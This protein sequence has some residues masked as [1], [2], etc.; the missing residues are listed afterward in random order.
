MEVDLCSRRGIRV[1]SRQ[2][3]S[4][5]S[6]AAGHDC[7]RLIRCASHMANQ[8]H[9]KH[10]RSSYRFPGEW[11]CG[12]FQQLD[13]TEFRNP[14][15]IRVLMFQRECRVLSG[16][17][18]RRRNER[19]RMV[20][21]IRSRRSGG[22]V[23]QMLPMGPIQQLLHLWTHCCLQE[24]HVLMLV[25]VPCF[26]CLFLLRLDGRTHRETRLLVVDH[27]FEIF[28]ELPDC[29]KNTSHFSSAGKCTR[30]ILCSGR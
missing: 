6:A 7:Q 23:F 25:F 3:S 26:R 28:P 17:A 12:L 11:P 9:R 24:L 2:L 20:S 15:S 30:E 1:P 16:Q 22:F 14:G 27:L 13:G 18:G 21:L 19:R 4:Q 29:R 8:D 10:G 5:C